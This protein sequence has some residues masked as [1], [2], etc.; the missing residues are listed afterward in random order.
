MP[1]GV[2][3]TGQVTNEAQGTIFWVTAFSAMNPEGSAEG[4]CSFAFSANESAETV[5]SALVTAY[6]AANQG[7][8]AWLYSD[9]V[10]VIFNPPSI[11]EEVADMK[12]DNQL[13]TDA[14]VALGNGLTATKTVVD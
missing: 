13:V 9:Q 8:M 6:N 11:G 14:G 4:A 12:V 10:S 7:S 2:G 5:A 3:W 1:V